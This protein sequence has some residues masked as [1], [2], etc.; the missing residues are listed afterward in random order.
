VETIKCS[1]ILI[2]D[3][4]NTQK[5]FTVDI[6]KNVSV[7]Y[8]FIRLKPELENFCVIKLG[9]LWLLGDPI[10]FK[11]SKISHSIFINS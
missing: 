11:N 10:L 1:L 6:K 3:V 2:A 9:W 8:K 4:M 5:K 7:K